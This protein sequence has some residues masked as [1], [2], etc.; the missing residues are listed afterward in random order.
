MK[1]RMGAMSDSDLTRISVGQFRVGIVGLLQAIEEVKNLPGQS[2]AEIAE[3]L[4]HKLKPKNYIP[5]PA[6]EEYKQLKEFGG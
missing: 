2:E 6:R 4:L 3:A 5:K 1:P